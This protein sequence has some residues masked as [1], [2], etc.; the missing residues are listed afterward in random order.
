MNNLLADNF[1]LRENI[2]SDADA[3]YFFKI[4][5]EPAKKSR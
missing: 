1:F 3:N 5:V 2:Y 4:M